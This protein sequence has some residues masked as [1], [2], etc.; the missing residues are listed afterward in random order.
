ML[1]FGGGVDKNLRAIAG[2]YFFYYAFIGVF[3]PYWG[4]YLQGMGLS[5]IDIGL[6]L[7]IQPVMRMV[8]PAV[9]GWLSDKT[10][11]RLAIIQLAA[12]LNLLCYL[13]VFA[14]S[15]FWGMFILLAAIGFLE[16]HDAVGGGNYLN[17]SRCQD[18]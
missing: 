8:A 6:L 2:F 16:C 7:S 14:V 1:L 18:G 3:A 12:L 9:W 4:L 5:A 11:M 17:L 10:G 13:G 15:A